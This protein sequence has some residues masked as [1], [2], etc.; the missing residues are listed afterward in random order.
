MKEVRRGKQFHHYSAGSMIP[1]GAR[2]AKGGGKG[3]TYTFYAGMEAVSTEDLNLLFNDAEVLAVKD[4]NCIYANLD[5][6]YRIQ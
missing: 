3:D 4:C 1:K 2:E 6:N 5:S